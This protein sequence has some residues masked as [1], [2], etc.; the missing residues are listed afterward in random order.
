MNRFTQMLIVVLLMVGCAVDPARPFG[1]ASEDVT[2]SGGA[3]GSIGA[4]GAG[5]SGGSDTKR[6]LGTGCTDDGQ[7]GSGIC[8]GSATST[9]CCDGRA[10]ACNECVA[11]RIT[12]KT[13]G[14]SCG[15]RSCDPTERYHRAMECRRGSCE[16]ITTDC[17]TVSRDH[18]C[19][20][21]NVTCILASG[22]VGGCT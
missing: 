20:L 4:G 22:P 18:T 3:G 5:G 6:P 15:V 7:C 9:M 12:P 13:D 17:C 10:D 11:G 2:A 1:D 16:Q 19:Y 8:T 21:G 14:T